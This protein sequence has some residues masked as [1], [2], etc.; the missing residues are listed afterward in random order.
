MDGIV[1]RL[2]PSS[3]SG[4]ALKTSHCRMKASQPIAAAAMIQSG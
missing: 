1:I 2:R 4:F 3:R